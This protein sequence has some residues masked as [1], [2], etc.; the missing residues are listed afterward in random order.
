V[1]ADPLDGLA[2]AS[3]CARCKREL[4]Q[5]GYPKIAPV[6]CTSCQSDEEVGP[7]VIV[8]VKEPNP[9]FGRRDLWLLAVLIG[10]VLYAVAHG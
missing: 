9:T 4:V 5:V 1:S 6:T 2:V 8:P 10:V 3:H 7:P